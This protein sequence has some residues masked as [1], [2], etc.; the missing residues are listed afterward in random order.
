VASIIG[1]LLALAVIP[2]I[3]AAW[4]LSQFRLF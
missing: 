1:V 4:L 3:V 2:L